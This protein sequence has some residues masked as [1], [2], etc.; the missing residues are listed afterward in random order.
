METKTFIHSGDMGDCIAGMAAVKEICERDNAKAKVVLDAT[1]G[2]YSPDVIQMNPLGNKF[3]LK[4]A[5]FIKPLIE[6]QDYVA[7]VEIDTL[8]K[9]Y[10]GTMKDEVDYDL[11]AFRRCFRD[12]SVQKKTNLN[13]EYLQQYALGLDY[14]YKGGWMDI[15]VDKEPK[16]ILFC[17]STRYQSAHIGYEWML[18]QAK[19]NNTP[20]KFIGTDLEYECLKDCFRGLEPPRVKVSN[21]L[22]LAK[23]IATSQEIV[24]NGTLALWIAYAIEHPNITHELAE[25]IPTTFYRW[26]EGQKHPN[27]R[28]LVGGHFVK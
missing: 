17:R 4:A 24:V 23:E 27:V 7:E 5:E 1:G 11:N 2:I 22:E 8:G 3:N 18:A 15:K 12:P 16:G 21:A 26:K 9:Y 28:Y 19:R 10:A 25:D 20:R 14:G 13:L 6:A